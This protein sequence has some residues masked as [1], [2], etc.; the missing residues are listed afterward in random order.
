MT[1][2]TGLIARAVGDLNVAEMARGG[3]ATFFAG[4]CRGALVGRGSDFDFVEFAVTNASYAS[5]SPKYVASTSWKSASCACQSSHYQ[6]T[7]SCAISSR[8]FRS[9]G[10]NMLFQISNLL[11]RLSL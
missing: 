9:P 4:A 8:S 1:R 11:R 10:V 7:A 2:G 3:E 6:R 5:G